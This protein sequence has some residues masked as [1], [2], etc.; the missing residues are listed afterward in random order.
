MPQTTVAYWYRRPITSNRN[1]DE[2]DTTQQ[3]FPG[4]Q[5][6]SAYPTFS[7]GTRDPQPRRRHPFPTGAWQIHRQ[8]FSI[9]TNWL[10]SEILTGPWSRRRTRQA[11]DP[12]PRME[13]QRDHASSFSRVPM[14]KYGSGWQSLNNKLKVSFSPVRPYH[15]GS[16]QDSG[17]PCRQYLGL[18]CVVISPCS[19]NVYVVTHKENRAREWQRRNTHFV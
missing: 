6:A 1:R 9:V 19:K 17:Y 15:S 14:K 12:W 3:P 2:S 10:Q 11:W 4:D 13:R 5:S 8:R 16:I 7:P 18:R